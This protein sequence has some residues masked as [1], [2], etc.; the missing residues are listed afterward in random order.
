[1]FAR[2][3]TRQIGIVVLTVGLFAGPCTA[4]G[5]FRPDAGGF[6]PDEL[7]AL[8]QNNDFPR[9]SSDPGSPFSFASL[10]RAGH[11]FASW[12]VWSAIGVTSFFGAISFTYASRDTIFQQ[13]I[14]DMAVKSV[15][16]LCSLATSALFWRSFQGINAYF[17]K[18][19]QQKQWSDE[20]ATQ[21]REVTKRVQPLVGSVTKSFDVRSV[22]SYIEHQ[23]DVTKD[24]QRKQVLIIGRAGL[25]KSTLLTHVLASA[26][27]RGQLSIEITT[28]TI[29]SYQPADS[30]NFFSFL[31]SCGTKKKPVLVALD[32][33]QSLVGPL[34]PDSRVVASANDQSLFDTIVHSCSKYPNLLFVAAANISYEELKTLPKGQF[35]ALNRRFKIAELAPPNTQDRLAI[36][37]ALSKRLGVNL[38]RGAR[39]GLV[40]NSEGMS[41]GDIE[42][43]LSK[44]RDSARVDDSGC[45]VVCV[46]HMKGAYEDYTRKDCGGFAPLAMSSSSARIFVSN[47]EVLGVNSIA[48]LSQRALVRHRKRKRKKRSPAELSAAVP[49]PVVSPLASLSPIP[50]R[51]IKK[52]P[53]AELSAASSLPV[54]SPLASLSPIP[55]A[56][57]ASEALS[58]PFAGLPPCIAA[59][60]GMPGRQSR[61]GSLSALPAPRSRA[62]SLPTLR[63]PALTDR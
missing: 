57:E 41:G 56:V 58:S 14:V 59:A 43:L 44:A 60:N 36:T 48:S 42:M 1:M 16:S 6:R 31:N 45:K 61:S 9:T 11:S 10:S 5:G 53:P 4:A 63:L 39:A 24:E 21:A 32:E 8:Q 52:R 26:A 19:A 62:R 29:R 15:G 51:R 47:S 18:H 17:M 50:A 38:T 46:R 34:L 35:D 49:L 37:I 2:T 12:P 3:A 33:F 22:M 40:K 20:M 7:K 27:R 55:A 23:E 28:P 13:A 25:G 30:E 54:V